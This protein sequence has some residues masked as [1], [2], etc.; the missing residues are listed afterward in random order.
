MCGRVY[1]EVPAQEVDSGTLWG[2]T[3]DNPLFING[4]KP[5]TTAWATPPP[6][7]QQWP[8]S[9][10]TLFRAEGE[11]SILALE[12]RA[13]SIPLRPE[14]HT[15]MPRTC[16]ICSHQQRDLM[17]TALVRG[18]SYRVIA[19]QFRVGHDA[20]QRHAKQHIARDLEMAKGNETVQ[21]AL[22][23]AEQIEELRRHTETVLTNQDD[24]SLLLKAIARRERQIELVARLTGAFQRDK[25]NESDREQKRRHCEIAIERVMREA[26]VSREVA[27]DALRPYMPDISHYI[28]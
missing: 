10:I 28:N 17:E 8:T 18:A 26:S 9:P 5:I 21:R 2:V 15:L 6:T 25:Q 3:V 27:I 11:L 13:C 22:S 4:G 7:P 19:R 14:S 23:L 24:Q 12:R 1:I 16:T 20:L